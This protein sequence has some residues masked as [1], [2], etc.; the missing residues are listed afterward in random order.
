MLLLVLI[1]L[2]LLDDLLLLILCKI[3]EG[4]VTLVKQLLHISK[5]INQIVTVLLLILDNLV[6]GHV[7]TD[8][9]IVLNLHHLLTWSRNAHRSNMLT[10][11]NI[12]IWTSICLHLGL[13]NLVLICRFVG[14]LCNYILAELIGWLGIDGIP[15]IDNLMT[16]GSSL[17]DGHGRRDLATL[18]RCQLIVEII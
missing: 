14:Y 18:S 13:S 1:D 3:D 16:H 12:L 17:R 2:E 7:Q 5:F 4:S 9:H 6:V 15:V 11:N 8:I 10:I